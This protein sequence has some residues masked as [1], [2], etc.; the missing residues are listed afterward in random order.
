M[1]SRLKYLLLQ[2]SELLI[3]TW[4]IIITPITFHS[5]G[6]K[7]RITTGG[8]ILALARRRRRWWPKNQEIKLGEEEIRS[9]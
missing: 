1:V 4:K 9:L 7:E 8:S 5:L 2:D 3:F 6:T